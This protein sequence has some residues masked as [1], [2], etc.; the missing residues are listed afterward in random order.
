[1]NFASLRFGAPEEVNFGFGSKLID[2]QESGQ[3][4]ILIFEGKGNGLSKDNFTAK[5]LGEDADGKLLFGYARL[6]WVDYPD[7]PAT[8]FT[9]SGLKLV[10]EE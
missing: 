8:V 2:L 4:M 1:M 6:P 3:D 7:A 10:N 9:A 5:L